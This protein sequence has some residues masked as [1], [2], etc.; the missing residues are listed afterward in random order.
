VLVACYLFLGKPYLEIIALMP[1]LSI[2][3]STA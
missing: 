3:S 2:V 1:V